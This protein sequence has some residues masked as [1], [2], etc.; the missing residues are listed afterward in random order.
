MH[1][2]SLRNCIYLLLYVSFYFD[3]KTSGNVHC[4]D[5]ISNPGT[6]TETDTTTTHSAPNIQNI[7]DSVKS[8]TSRFLKNTCLH[9]GVICMLWLNI[10]MRLMTSFC[11]ANSNLCRNLYK[12]RTTSFYCISFHCVTHWIGCSCESSC[13]K[14]KL[15]SHFI[16]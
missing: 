8:M 7:T 6:S 10:V 4:N 12:N 16:K 15:Y 3:Y 9:Y 5:A 1:Y 2:Q 14:V 13:E 11:R